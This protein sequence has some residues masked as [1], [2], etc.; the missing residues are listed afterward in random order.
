MGMFKMREPR[1]FRRVSIYTDERR[2]KLEKLV[3]EVKREQGELPPEQLDYTTDKF[4]G[5][6]GK[7]TPRTQ[8]YI[9]HGRGMVKWPVALIVI[10]LLFMLWRYLLTGDIHF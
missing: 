1:K 7:F 5:K 8:T 9:E 2:D 3:N 4:R 6:F 10:I